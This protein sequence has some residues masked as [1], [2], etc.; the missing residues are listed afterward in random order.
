MF[1]NSPSITDLKLNHVY[2]H[3]SPTISY[4]YYYIILSNFNWLNIA[5]QCLTSAQKLRPKVKFTFTNYY[6]Y[7]FLY[8]NILHIIDS[9]YFIFII[10]FTKQ[11]KLD[12]LNIAN[13]EF[14]ELRN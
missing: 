3:F 1:L 10:M 6:V 14:A 5:N 8:E 13:I 2:I 12:R 4:I 9:L 11:K 7:I